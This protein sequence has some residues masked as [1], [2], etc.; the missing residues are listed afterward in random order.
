[1]Q[2]TSVRN[3][4][5]VELS[6]LGT[7]NVF[8]GA[9]GSGKTSVL[10]SLFLLG[11]ARSFRATQIKTVISHGAQQC[12]V[13]GALDSGRGS[14]TALGVQRDIN[15][16]LEA[17]IAGKPV[18]A[19]SEL[20][21]QFPLQVINAESFSLL[22]GSPG[23]RRQFLDWGVFHVEHGFYP[24]WKRFQRA[25]RQR[26]SL[27]RQ[28]KVAPADL[29]PWN[30]EFAEAGE[31]VDA[32]RDRYLRALDP[33]FKTLVSRLSPA[34]SELEL[35][36]RRG[37]KREAALGEALEAGTATDL[38]QGFTH[39]GPQRADIRVNIAGRSAADVLSRGQQKLA[40]CALKLA[41]GRLLA[42][43][44]NRSCAYLVDDLPAELDRAH[45][46][47]V[48]EVLDELQAQVFLSCIER[49]EIAE[50]WPKSGI[51]RCTMFHVEQGQITKNAN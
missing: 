47:R 8:F 36:Y 42:D 24:V 6:G 17:K 13:F 10:E 15:G 1:M 51:E 45:C 23:H 40:V 44:E 29:D 2:I 41:Q 12:T 30:R 4:R 31:Q 34:L 33:W 49:E 50:T 3:L 28:G 7:V 25:L 27:L 26:N 43:H 5:H 32:F 22:T 46:Q 18:T 37:W 11:M 14:C 9:N 38:Q 35:Q 48:T 21:E 39:L 16:G 19:T 20:A